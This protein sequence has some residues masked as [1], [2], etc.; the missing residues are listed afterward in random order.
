MTEA[1]KGHIDSNWFL[2]QFMRENFK[3]LA[4]YGTIEKFLEE[5]PGTIQIIFIGLLVWIIFFKRYKVLFHSPPQLIVVITGCDSGFGQMMANQ[6]AHRGYR[7]V[8]L[9]YTN[10]GMQQYS[11]IS[12]IHAFRCDVTQADQVM[13]A[14]QEV[15]AMIAKSLEETSSSTSTSTK[16]KKKLRL[17]ALINNAGIA[18]MGLVDILPMSYF[19]DSMEVN[20]F[21]VI[22]VIKAFLPLLKATYGSRI[23]NISS[24]AG[25]LSGPLF[26]AYSASKHALEGLIKA[27]RHELRNWNIHVAL[28]NPAFMRTPIINNSIDQAITIFRN[29]P[30][31][32]RGQ[33]SE[34][35]LTQNGQLVKNAAEDP[36]VVVNEILQLLTDSSPSLHSHTGWQSFFMRFVRLLPESVLERIMITFSPVDVG[37]TKAALEI[38]QEKI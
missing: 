29:A 2:N 6:I 14:V 4:F 13:A 34:K 15:N 10:E 31:E 24:Q 36:Q 32:V 5:H 26:G 23:I 27:L 30:L 17:W 35:V 25:L 28:V 3:G 22:T 12:N 1:A 18:P 38:F 9:C 16:S 11:S 20:Y 33:Y 19:R 21:G 7:V 8:A 37:P